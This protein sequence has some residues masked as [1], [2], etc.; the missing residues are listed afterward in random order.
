MT[1]VFISGSMNIKNLDSNVIYRLN[2]IVESGFDVIVG[3]ANGVDTSIQEFFLSKDYKKVKVYCAGS[4]PRNNVGRWPT[5][6]VETKALEGSR[7]FYTAKDLVMAEDCDFGLMVWDTKS[8]GTLSNTLELL[9]AEKKSRV[10]INK[11]KE[12]IKVTTVD[13]LKHLISFMSE[14]AR[15]KAEAKIKLAQQIEAMS[16]KQEGLF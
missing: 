2:H 7:S 9:K 6:V 4:Q 15:N 11:N 12:F 16:F 14:F 10:Y 1:K 13:D 8:T 5:E 3:D